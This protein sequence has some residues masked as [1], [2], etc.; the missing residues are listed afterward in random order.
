MERALPA[1]VVAEW[2]VR[3]REHLEDLGDCDIA[4][5]VGGHQHDVRDVEL[6]TGRAAPHVGFGAELRQCRCERIGAAAMGDEV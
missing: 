3:I 6:A 2:Q 1:R 5:E 4:V